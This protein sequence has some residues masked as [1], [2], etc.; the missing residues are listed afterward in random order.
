MN[1]S[2]EPCQCR[3]TDYL[4]DDFLCLS[5]PTTIPSAVVMIQLFKISK[6]YTN[7]KLM[8]QNHIEYY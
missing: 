4:A 6:A 8:H 5:I 2:T 1:I 7:I 3:R